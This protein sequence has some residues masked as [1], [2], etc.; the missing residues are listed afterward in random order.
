MK[1][2]F[3]QF[4][5]EF[6]KVDENLEKVESIIGNVVCDLLV[7]P[8][9]FSTGYTFKSKAEVIKFGES[10]PD[11]K[12]L[13]FLKK[14]ATE[15]KMSIV[16]G[17]VERDGKKVYNSS[18]LYLENSKYFIYRKKHLYR[19]EKN[20]FDTAYEPYKFF[21][22]QNGIKVGLLICFDWLFPEAMRQLAL[23]GAQ[24]ICHSANLV[25]DVCQDAMVTRALENRVFV[26]TAN[27]TGMEKRGRFENRFTGMSQIVSP[28]GRILLR[29]GEDDEVISVIDINPD[30]ALNKFLNPQ[31]NIF[32]DRRED[33]Y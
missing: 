5:P 22:I 19:Y 32:S 13:K 1:V 20:I 28:E 3:L 6:G 33:I 29:A 26:I 25:M 4:N 30:D 11:G 24:V 9:L 7:L 8:E 15:K 16:G 23:S 14:V 21:L 27:R 12:T 18:L 10:I 2:G 31:N 17:F